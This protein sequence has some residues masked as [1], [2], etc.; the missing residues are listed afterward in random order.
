[1]E[2]IKFLQNN[3]DEGLPHDD[4]VEQDKSKYV[5]R[6]QI[7]WF[8]AIGFLVLHLF[9]TYGLYLFLTSTMIATIL[10]SKYKIARDNEY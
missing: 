2:M 4:S 8:N 5:Y 7:V 6:R 3:A 1:M 10:W 9:A